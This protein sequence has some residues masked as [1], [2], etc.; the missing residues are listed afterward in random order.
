M[1]PRRA[2]A[3]VWF[4]PPGERPGSANAPRGAHFR[5]QADSNDMRQTTANNERI[6]FFVRAIPAN[7]TGNGLQRE[8]VRLGLRCSLSAVSGREGSLKTRKRWNEQQCSTTGMVRAVCRSRER[9]RKA[10]A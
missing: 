6:S 7:L 5:K 1:G 8:N 9:Q 3:G 2:A 10:I 4:N